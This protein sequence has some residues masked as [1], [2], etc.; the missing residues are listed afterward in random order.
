MKLILDILKR[1]WRLIMRPDDRS[2]PTYCEL[3][4]RER[5]RMLRRGVQSLEAILDEEERQ[6]AIRA[7]KTREKSTQFS[8]NYPSIIL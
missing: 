3:I 2:I 5:L 4:A 6:R 1:R 8:T 7:N